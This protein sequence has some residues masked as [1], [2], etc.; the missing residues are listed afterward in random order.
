M[1]Q[2]DIWK[3]DSKHSMVF[4]I[5]SVELMDPLVVAGKKAY[6]NTWYQDETG[7][8]VTGLQEIDGKKYFFN[9][10]TG[11]RESGF[12]KIDGVLYFFSSVDGYASSGWKYAYNEV[13][14]QDETGVVA[15]GK[16]EY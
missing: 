5:I 8:V 9:E 11:Y 12:K 16:K 3:Q 1:K 7:A 14:Y 15:T 4:F 2:Q 6:G 13:W 10:T